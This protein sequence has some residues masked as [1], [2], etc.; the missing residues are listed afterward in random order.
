VAEWIRSSAI[1]FHCT[2]SLMNQAGLNV[3]TS[4]VNQTFHPSGVG[5]LVAVSMQWVTAVEGCEGKSVRL[6]DGQRT[7]YTAGGATCHTLV[8]C[9]PHGSVRHAWCT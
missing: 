2:T 3:G 8:S 1:M 5:K 9:S 7:A 6:Y 4:T